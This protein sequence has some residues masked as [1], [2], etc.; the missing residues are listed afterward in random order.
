MVLSGGG[1]YDDAGGIYDTSRLPCQM[2]PYRALAAMDGAA[3]RGAIIYTLNADHDNMY[4]MNGLSDTTM[5]I[6]HH[7]PDWFAGMRRQT[8]AMHGSEKN[9]FTTVF[10][11]DVAH[12]PSWVDR[13]G[14]LWLDDQLHFTNW[15]RAQIEAMPLTHISEWI[16]ANNVFIAKNYMREISEG[17]IMAVGDDV[18]GVKRE[19]L[20]VLPDADWQRLKDRLVYDAWAEKIMKKYPP[21]TVPDLP[22]APHVFAGATAMTLLP[23]P[24]PGSLPAALTAPAPAPASAAKP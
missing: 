17:G 22:G 5:D 10:Y 2:P 21:E 9:V 15:T 19:D 18:P 1:D 3:N 16:T 12:R 14:F 23:P 24:V 7:G 20:M 13:D 8:I 4:V 11:P 6:P